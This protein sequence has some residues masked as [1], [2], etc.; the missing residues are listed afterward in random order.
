MGE[1]RTH[2]TVS[3]VS[4]V[5]NHEDRAALNHLRPDWTGDLITQSMLTALTISDLEILQRGDAS[6]SDH[7]PN[8]RCQVM[9]LWL[10][11]ILSRR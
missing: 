8:A 7:A 10:M 11:F 3:T 9:P 6:Q 2:N 1:N 5:S 4:R